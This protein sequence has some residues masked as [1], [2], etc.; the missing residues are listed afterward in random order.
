MP[1]SPKIHFVHENEPGTPLDATQIRAL[2]SHVRQVNLERLQQRTTQR[3]ENFRSLSVDDFSQNG[4]IRP[5]KR[6]FVSRSEPRDT[7]TTSQMTS[8]PDEEARIHEPEQSVASSRRYSFLL[9]GRLHSDSRQGG[10]P[11]S[12]IPGPHPYTSDISAVTGLDEARVNQ[13]LTSSKFPP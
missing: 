5:E 12:S 6:R 1:R 13:L 7:P 9:P 8:E 4:E 11:A 10:R 2:R 3:M